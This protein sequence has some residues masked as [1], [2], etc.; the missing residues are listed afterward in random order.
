MRGLFCYSTHFISSNHL[1]LVMHSNLDP[2]ID[3]FVPISNNSQFPRVCHRYGK[4]HRFRVTG[5]VGMGTVLNLAY[6]HITVYP[7]HGITG[8]LWV[9]YHMVRIILLFFL[10][11]LIVVFVVNSLCHPWH[12]QIWLCCCA[13]IQF[14]SHHQTPTSHSHSHPTSKQSE[15]KFYISKT[16]QQILC[17]LMIHIKVSILINMYVLILYLI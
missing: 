16:N 13:Y 8:M 17:R 1:N 2:L 5:F 11:Y 7:C 6:P 10:S 9:Y 3:K 14:T 15:L 12:N 4:T